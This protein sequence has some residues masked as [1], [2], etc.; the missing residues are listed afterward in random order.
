MD[1]IKRIMI[2]EQQLPPNKPLLQAIVLPPFLFHHHYTLKFRVCY[3][4]E[5]KNVKMRKIILKGWSYMS[6]PANF[7]RE[8]FET[9]AEASLLLPDSNERSKSIEHKDRFN[10]GEKNQNLKK[11]EEN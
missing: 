3:C 9:D 6:L 10:F 4:F 5:Y 11:N 2:H 8:P 1:K 7:F